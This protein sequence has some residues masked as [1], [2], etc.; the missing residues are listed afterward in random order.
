MSVRIGIYDFFANMIPGVFYILVVAFG[1]NLFGIVDIHLVQ[2]KDISLIGFIIL[3]AIGFIV[4]QILDWAG[5][6]WF[7]FFKD[8]NSIERKV[9]FALFQ[10]HYPWLE[11]TLRHEDWSLMLQAIKIQIPDA[12]VEIEQQNALHIMLRNISL[13]LFL[14]SLIF[15]FA[16]FIVFPHIGNLAV[17]I[18][19][20]ALSF[21]ALDRSFHRRRWFYIGIY[22]AFTTNLLL[23]LNKLESTI[24]VK[25]EQPEL[26]TKDED[27]DGG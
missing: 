12:T 14:T 6:K 21:L 5:Y 7:C 16:F 13:G 18:L 24:D 27:K 2:I 23:Q 17:A 15:F 8:R 11:V 3:I 19:A 22:E 4:G 20:L 9:T 1:L 26:V 25:P 10:Q